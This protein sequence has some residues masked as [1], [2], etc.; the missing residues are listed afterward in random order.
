MK[1]KITV[2]GLGE[3]GFALTKCLHEDGHEV[4]AIDKNMEII[5]D[6]KDFCTTAVC[7]DSTDENALRAQGLEDM[8]AVIIAAADNLETNI[9]TA[10]IV[11][12]IGPRELIVRYRT[13]LHIRILKM[14]GIDRVFNPEV[15]AAG[16]MAE[17]FKYRGI[18]MSAIITDE[19]R[20]AEVIL[21]KIFFRKT[22][23][24]AKLKEK[25]NLNV[26]TILRKSD[27]DSQKKETIVGIP[28]SDTVLHENDLL[29]IFATNRDLNKF[30]ETM[31]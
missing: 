31:E 19:Y 5:E 22:L 30:L 23:R 7:L 17:E 2:L 1:Q 18:R 29:V 21:P 10:D 28:R 8:D 26:V 12:K 15:R 6:V 25:Y 13:K 27:G 24:E 20:I 3:F 9:A 11:K 16:N 4:I 14:M